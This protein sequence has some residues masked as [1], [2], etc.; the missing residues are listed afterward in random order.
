MMNLKRLFRSF[1]KR[2]K[3][4][5]IKIISLSIGLALGLVL[6]AKVYFEQS[7][8][9]F[10]PDNDRIYQVISNYSTTEGNKA[11][12]QTPGA[13]AVGMK[14]ELPEIE[15]ATRYTWL[16]FETVMVT[17]DKKKYTGNV[18]L[19]D[20]CLFD[21]FPRPVLA[22]DVKEVLSRPMYIMISRKIAEKMG[23]I[24]QAIGQ[25]FTFDSR[26]GKP[27]TVGGVFEDMP[28]NSHL[29]YDV[30]VSMPSISQFMWD[31]TMNWLGNDRYMAYVKLLPGVKPEVLEPGIEKMK[32]KY[33][34]LEELEKSGIDI[35]WDF[36]PLLEIHV[37]DEET[38]RMTLILSLLAIALLFTA[39]MNY[40]LIVISSLVN[41]SKEMAVNKC[42]GASEK[43]IYLR[44]LSETLLDI[45]VSSA[46]AILLIFV[47]RGT[48][49]S[50]LNT[51]VSDL[52]TLKSILL[53]IGVCVFVF[54]VAAL[55]P[56]HLYARIPVA[57]AFR[58]FTESKR[59]WKLGLLFIQFI[60]AGLFVTLLVIIGRQYDFML[61]KNPGYTYNNLAYCSLSGVD[62]ELRQKALDET[63]RLS[64]VAEVSSC[65]QLFFDFASGNNIR[66]PNGEQ[67]LFNIADQYAVGNG[68]LKLMEVPIIE[69]RS[70]IENTP[71]SKE[72]M[73]SRSFI[74]KISKHVDWPDG[75]VGKNIYISEHSR[76]LNDTYTI[77]GV[78]EEVCMGIIG[79]QDTRASVMFYN[80]KPSSYLIIKFHEQ[81]AEA[82]EKVSD[83][84]TAL[85]PDKDIQVYSYAGEMRGKYSDSEKF[86]DSVLIGGIVTLLICLIGLIGY[87]NDEMNRRK[88]ETAIR[89][90]N[91]ATTVDILRLFIKDISWMAVPAI[92]LGCMI[93]Y[94]IANTWLDNFADKAEL[95]IFLFV[96]CAIA[97]FI[98][99]LAA[100]IINCYQAANEN[101]AES[102]KSE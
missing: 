48:I 2:G 36:K 81:T 99:I 43:N 54:F 85:L 68:Y 49:L 66:L 90:V 95:T 61:N 72:V 96:G 32:E 77:C 8:N 28:N 26:P 25:T 20:S 13:V 23:G 11:Y 50:L 88:K 91:G 94:F 79:H 39:V 100:V 17:P 42:Y 33:L 41:R 21:V 1:F 64:E 98:I 16:A 70:F 22:G 14:T 37:G 15:V 84:L 75:V 31:G 53:L 40:V 38:K 56:G 24:N 82:L 83:M 30:I 92:T 46:V 27:V 34:P 93:A 80:E 6:I 9:D 4:N 67:E 78:Y 10:F 58:N 51:T 86:R 60:A 76:G 5:L 29:S 73:V 69:G 18:I 52:F 35:G 19:G 47:F 97:V 7:Y 12:P 71:S 101:P 89:K 102:V 63:L 65:S 87:T 74:D 3:N 62:S 55:I 44:M 57:V 59:Y 45:V